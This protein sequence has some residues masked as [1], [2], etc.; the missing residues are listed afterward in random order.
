[1]PVGVAEGV[2][3][4]LLVLLPVPEPLTERAPLR[5]EVESALGVLGIGETEDLDILWVLSCSSPPR[6]SVP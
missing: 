4:V 3:G 5:E 6:S 2:D 1:M